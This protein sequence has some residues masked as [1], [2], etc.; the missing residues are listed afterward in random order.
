MRLR[1]WPGCLLLIVLAGAAGPAARAAS[2]PAKVR[3][4][5]AEDMW[6]SIARQLGGDHADVTSVIS[7]PDTDP[8]DYEATP[9]DGAAMA[10]AQV[11]VVNGVG[12]DGWAHNLLAAN[13]SS[14]RTVVTVGD[15]VGV[16]DG[17]NPHQWYSPKSVSAV[18]AAITD[19]LKQADPADAAY[20]DARRQAY[21]AEG[22]KRYNDLRAQIKAQY[23]GTAVG[24]S[25]SIFAPLAADLGLKL[26]TPESF[27]DAV[28]EGSEP[29][30]RDKRTV[31][32][33]ITGRQI[34]VFVVNSQNS[35][36]DVAALVDK[37]KAAGVPVATVTET[38]TPKGVSFQ[39]WQAD[40]LQRLADALAAAN[41]GATAVSA[42]QVPAAP[43]APAPAGPSAPG[44]APARWL[45]LLAG[46][47]VL[48]GVGLLARAGAGSGAHDPC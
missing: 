10:T 35:T 39:D 27:L 28:S 46:A 18:I 2:A 37:A 45:V 29:T 3:V 24:A 6:G 38:L 17:G 42:A 32:R 33:Q 23:G 36:P 4:V 25:E 5:A 20:F 15:V 41:G 12:Y 30:A 44:G 7:D 11:A 26:L 47:T 14:S 31:D 19:A 40:Q 1:H 13:P 8:H 48:G 22:L 16:K 43:S 9:R 21:E 34:R